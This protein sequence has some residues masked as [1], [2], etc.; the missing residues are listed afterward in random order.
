MPSIPED[1][2][3]GV[4]DEVLM[5]S[6]RQGK[7]YALAALMERWEVSMK[8]F[9]LRLGVPPSD[10][11]DIAQ[12]AFLRLYRSREKYRVGAPFKPWLLTIAGNLARNRLRWRFRRREESIQALDSDL[13]GGFDLEDRSAP[14]APAEIEKRRRGAVVQSAIN[15]L[16]SRLREALVYVEIE[17]LTYRQ[18]AR[19]AGCSEKAIETR[20]Y[21]AKQSLRSTLRSLLRD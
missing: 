21:R 6:L 2:P 15:A 16:P 14:N 10:V 19:V 12:E 5:E 9:L 13:V 20:L 7:D 1:D 11:E 17:D 8:V 18:A 4:S 3:T